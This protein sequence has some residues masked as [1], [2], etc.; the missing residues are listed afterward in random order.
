MNDAQIKFLRVF[1]FY[2]G[3]R[4]K[5]LKA[6]GIEENH[7]SLWM[8]DDDFVQN[9]NGTQNEIIQN[10]LTDFRFNYIRMVQELI[11]KGYR[12]TETS[13]KSETSKNGVTTL[14]WGRKKKL[15]M[16][17]HSYLKDLLNYNNVESSINNLAQQGLIP[18]SMARRFLSTAQEYQS[19]LAACFGDNDDDSKFSDERAI[20]LIK[21]ALLGNG[22]EIG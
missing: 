20:A 4:N 19:K 7:L 18:R 5:T 15:K 13:W 10:I 3:D 1:Q 12:E 21:Q 6:C 16:I 17:P 2:Q 11:V 8:Q 22:E 9:F 14:N